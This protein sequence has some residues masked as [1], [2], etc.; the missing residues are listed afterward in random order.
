MP[1][2]V[3]DIL[4]N[5]RKTHRYSQETMASFLHVSQATYNNWINKKHK[6]SIEHY[7]A[8]AVLCGVPLPEILPTGFHNSDQ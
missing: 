7:P 6:I 4:E 5:Y 2:C 1:H 8:I 3:I